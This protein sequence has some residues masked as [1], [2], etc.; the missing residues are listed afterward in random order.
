MTDHFDPVRSPQRFSDRAVV[1]DVERL[2]A[3]GVGL[4]RRE[5]GRVVLV[6]GG[7]PGERLEVSVIERKGSEHGRIVRVLE[8][9]PGR[10]EPVCPY[11]IEGCGGC[12]LAHL[13]HEAQLDAKIGIVADAL[14]RLGKWKEPVVAAGPVLD[15]WGFRTVVRDSEWL[16]VT[17]YL[18]FH[19]VR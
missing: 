12:D 17:M 5:D 16:R 7:L 13:A 8:A 19:L 1:V 14:R 11:V 18:I 10:I 2:V 6:D 15:P 9:S 3:G 4:S